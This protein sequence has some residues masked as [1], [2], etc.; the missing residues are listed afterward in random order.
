MATWG[1]GYYLAVD[2]GQIDAVR[3]ERLIGQARPLLGSA[4]E[5][6][7]MLRAALSV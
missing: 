1:A 6:A 2:P 3:F 7:A 4:P 5:A